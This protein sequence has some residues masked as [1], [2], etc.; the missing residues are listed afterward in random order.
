MSLKIGD[1]APSFSLPDQHGKNH[2]LADY[3]GSWLLIYFYPKDATPGC[4]IEAC[5]FRDDHEA[6]MQAGI[7][8]VGVS[9]DSVA[10]HAKFA[11]K[12][13]LPFT[14]LADIDKSMVND[15]GVWTKK[16][17]M[18]REYLGT[19]RHS[20]LVDPDGRIAKIYEQV[21]PAAHAK[22]V[23]ADVTGMESR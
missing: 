13:R 8:V 22:E 7:N 12:Q 3:A 5:A 9:T 6:A 23:V 18:G 17:F 14:L 20:F 15:Y 11:A 21:K 10:S 16:K 1:K 4:T 2:S 19:M